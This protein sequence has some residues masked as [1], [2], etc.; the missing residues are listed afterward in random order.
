[1]YDDA[2]PLARHPH[3]LSACKPDDSSAVRCPVKHLDMDGAERPPEIPPA[4]AADA[5]WQSGKH[6]P[7]LSEGG[8]DLLSS[9]RASGNG[10][11]TMLSYVLVGAGEAPKPPASSESVWLQ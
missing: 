1:M 5:Y 4:C 7:R 10:D 3:S 8:G 2:P 9:F 6:P 11:K